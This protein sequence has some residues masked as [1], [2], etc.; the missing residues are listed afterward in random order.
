[1]SLMLICHQRDNVT[2]LLEIAAEVHFFS[3]TSQILCAL[4]FEQL[5]PRSIQSDRIPHMML[6]TMQAR[7]VP[8]TPAFVQGTAMIGGV[9]SGAK[10]G[11]AGGSRINRAD[12]NAG[13]TERRGTLVALQA[14][15]AP[16]EAG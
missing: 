12:E 10:G 3:E 1:M 5:R 7:H 13:N 11:H 9:S 2:G 16:R 15:I 8:T 4:Q 6:R 14:D